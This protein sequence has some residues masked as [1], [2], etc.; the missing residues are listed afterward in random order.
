MCL[1]LHI[2]DL[3]P[4]KRGLNAYAKK[5]RPTPGQTAH[6]SQTDPVP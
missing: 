2:N 3:I 5:Y 1:V 6:S 4:M